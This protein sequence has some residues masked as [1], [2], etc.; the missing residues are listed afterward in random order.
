LLPDLKVARIDV[1]IDLEN[2]LIGLVK[3][4][5]RPDLREL[6]EAIRGEVEDL[7]EIVAVT[8]YADFDELNR[9]GGPNK[10]WQRELTLAGGE[11][12]YVVNQHGKNTAD[13]KIAND[14]HTLVTHDAGAGGIDIIALAMMDRDFRPIVETAKSRGKRVVVLALEGGLSRELEGV[15]SDV[16]YLD[17]RLR[18]PQPGAQ[19]SQAA[20]RHAP[21]P[22]NAALMLRI[23][24]WMNRNR[25][26]FVYRDSVEQEFSVAAEGLRK[27]IEDGWLTPGPNS[28]LD[29]QG[30]ARKLEPNPNNPVARAAQYLARWI[31]SRLDFCLRQRE[32]PHVD[33]NYL[34]NGMA[35]DRV[36]NQM[37][38][39]QTRG[40]AES[41]LYAAASAGL[42]VATEQPHP[43]TPTK[44]ITTWWLPEEEAAPPTA[45]AEEE[46]SGSPPCS[47]YLRHLL[48][49]KLSDGELTR[50]LFD[51]FRSVHR[52]VEGAP[53][54]TRIQ[55]L[56]EYVE[57]RN[58]Y[59][60]LLA[61]M[62][63]VNAALDEEPEAQPMAA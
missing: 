37:G 60:Q 5:W 3:R 44:T 59:D 35:R 48:T 19:R 36:L 53:K 17:S 24:A 56:L 40:E 55:A 63:E 21:Q 52:Q 62:R 22:E 15:A 45:E 2:I 61:A 11:S 49:H 34:A 28:P 31:P 25:W 38:I 18:L 8:G 30:Q 27:L 57:Q 23:A 16:R 39:G 4:D 9:N 43:Q 58:L 32:M 54:F 41:W 33:S 42:V 7:G 29:A 20:P 46:G 10:N 13:M 51:H 12:R 50:V 26:G 47:S 14:I 6:I 1:R